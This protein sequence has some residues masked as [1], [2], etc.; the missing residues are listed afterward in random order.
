MY[1]RAGAHDKAVAMF[2]DLRMFTEAEAF[3]KQHASAVAQQ[4]DTRLLAELS[5]HLQARTDH[6]RCQAKKTCAI[7]QPAG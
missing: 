6:H 7:R 3:E 1:A 5:A 4:E 2:R